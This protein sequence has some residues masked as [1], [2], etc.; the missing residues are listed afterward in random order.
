MQLWKAIAVQQFDGRSWQFLQSIL[1]K[2]Q[3][4]IISPESNFFWIKCLRQIIYYHLIHTHLLT[5]TLYHLW[6]CSQ[7]F[8]IWWHIFFIWTYF[9]SNV[10]MACTFSRLNVL[11][12][13]FAVLVLGKILFLFQII[14]L[15]MF[16]RQGFCLLSF[17]E[18]F[19]ESLLN[20]IIIFV[21]I[22]SL[23]TQ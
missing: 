23:L 2:I 11:L 10:L 22:S 8:F 14:H 19:A 17:V 4:L 15:R 12:F 20:L 7:N 18:A 13:F 16:Q 5:N 3:H 9:F 6:P 1:I 21:R